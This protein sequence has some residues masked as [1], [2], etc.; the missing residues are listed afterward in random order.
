MMAVFRP[1]RVDDTARC[2]ATVVFPAAP[3]LTN[4]GNGVH[5]LKKEYLHG[6]MPARVKVFHPAQ[7]ICACV[8]DCTWVTAGSRRLAL[9]AGGVPE[10]VLG[11]EV[12]PD[13]GVGFQELR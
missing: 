2:K 5:Q 13:L 11:L 10:V 1:A 8:H 4:D 12:H 7:R 9:G 6:C 3:F